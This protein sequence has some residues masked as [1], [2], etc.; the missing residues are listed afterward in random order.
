M[1]DN[2]F[3]EVDSIE[4]AIYLYKKAC[5]LNKSINFTKI[6]KW[7]YIC[8]GLYFAAYEK[9]LLTERPKAWD[10]GPVFPR[11][12]KWF[13]KNQN[14][15]DIMENKTSIDELK[16]YDDVINATLKHFGDWTS[17]ELVAWTHQID[18]AWHKKIKQ[19]E[20]YDS[21]DNYDILL[22]FRSLISNG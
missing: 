10:Y 20:R 2:A 11:V 22:D 15:L 5:E 8:Y 19:D 7:L 13:K 16:K 17:S 9:Q 3:G 14:R 1:C 18:K 6:Q 21:L 12:H 4:F